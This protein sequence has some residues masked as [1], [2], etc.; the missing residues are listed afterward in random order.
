MKLHQYH[1]L[2]QLHSNAFALYNYAC[3]NVIYL[4]PDLKEI[5]ERLILENTIDHLKTIYPKLYGTLIDNQ[6]LIE[7]DIDD[8]YFASQRLESIL[9]NK[10][11]FLLTINPTLDCNLRCWYCYQRHRKGLFMSQ[12]TMHSIQAFARGLVADKELESIFLSFFGGEPLLEAENI[13]LKI[14]KYI[15]KLCNDNHKKLRIHFTTNGTLLT[16]EILSC[17]YSLNEATTFQIPF[18]GSKSITIR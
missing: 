1:K 15:S 2:Y 5:V 11:E 18:D 13:A 10:K 12:E 4:T 6:F 3:D 14:S 9:C 17:I 7:D 16:K 8:F